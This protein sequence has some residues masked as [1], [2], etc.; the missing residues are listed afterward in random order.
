MKRLRECIE[1]VTKFSLQSHINK[2]LNFE[3]QLSPEFCSNLL[4]DSDPIDSNPDISKGVP[5]Y[6]LYKHLALAL[7]QSIVSGFIC[8]RQGNSALMRDEISSEQKEKWNKLVSTKG[9]ELI[10]IMNTIDFELHV[11]E[12]FFS[13]SRDGFKTIEG[14]CA[15]GKYNN[16][17][18]GSMILLNKCLVLEVQ[19]VRHY[20][21]F[22]KMLE[23]ESISQVLPGVN[24]TEEGLQT[25]R[26]FYAEEEERSNGV[27]AICVSNL[28]VQ[29]AISLAS[30]L[31]EL[32]YEGVQSLLGLAH[33][34]G[35]ISDAL[36]P[37]KSTLLS[38]FM[39]PYNPDVK[40]S[41]LT[42]GARA[43][44]K[45]VNRSS[46][47][48]WGNLNGSDSNKNKL[49]MGVIVDLIINSCWL[50][51]YTFQPHGDVFEIRVAEGYG[52]RWSKDGYKFIG[53]LEPYMDD[54]HLKGWKH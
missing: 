39:L 10:N 29:P 7:N 5:S 8:C 25:Y 48:Y 46:N 24:S 12:P 32:S 50:N 28:V 27:I 41:T 4:L 53:F 36:P 45:H 40:G 6:P 16:I 14:W 49:A 54:G 30:I 3:L 19:D 34:T 44:A 21:T 35:T 37:P 11:Q 43:L 20:A 17:E 26:K 22:S 13:M 38:S 47:K 31:S 9:L 52:A 42:H 2:S 15:V 1:E 33:T 23:A 18:P 51:M